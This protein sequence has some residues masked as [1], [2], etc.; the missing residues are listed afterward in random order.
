MNIAQTKGLFKELNP[1]F[2]EI[3]Q[4]DLSLQR[5]SAELTEDELLKHRLEIEVIK[6]MIC[7]STKMVHLGHCKNRISDLLLKVVAERRDVK[8]IIFSL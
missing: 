8:N 7:Q 6:A 2:L 5:T 3:R 1:L 4:L